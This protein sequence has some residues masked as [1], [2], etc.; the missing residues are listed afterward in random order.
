MY[1]NFGT[2][3]YQALILYRIEN[4][5]EKKKTIIYENKMCLRP[6]IFTEPALDDESQYYWGLEARC[7]TTADQVFN[8]FF[9]SL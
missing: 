1:N 8:E 2:V 3:Y 9:L 7:R 6:F 4:I 5:K